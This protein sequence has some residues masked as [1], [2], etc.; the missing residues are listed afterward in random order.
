MN[1]K[2]W[3]A[4]ITVQF[5]SRWYLCA[6]KSP[7][8][9]HPVSQKFPQRCLW[10]VS[11]VRLVD[12]GH[13]SSFQ[14]RSSSALC[15]KQFISKQIILTVLDTFI[16]SRQYT[17]QYTRQLMI[18]TYDD[19]CVVTELRFIPRQRAS[20]SENQPDL[21]LTSICKELAGIVQ[22]TRNGMGGRHIEFWIWR[23]LE[24]QCWD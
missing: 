4:L 12:D 7:Y 8:A 17:R 14:G 23:K 20:L 18:T 22:L 19:G 9:L 15:T 13:L 6:Q 21:I 10:N 1:N 5:S 3:F 16:T 11:N 24:E 2:D